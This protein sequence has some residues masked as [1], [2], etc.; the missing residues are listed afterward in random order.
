MGT[1]SGK[2]VIDGS[3]ANTGFATA[4]KAANAFFNV[5]QD[6]VKQLDTLATRLIQ[7]G[8]ASKVGF[9]AAITQAADFEQR[10]SAI[11]AV[12]GATKDQ[13]KLVSAEA[14]KIGA[15]TV[16]SAGQAADAIEELVKAGISL[17]NVLDGAGRA[18]VNLAA[19]GQIS[20]PEAA[21][22][23]A[24]AMNNFRLT[25]EDMPHIADLISG[26]ANA[27][28]ISVSEFGISLQ[29]AGAVAAL[30]GLKLDDLAVAIA[31]MGNAG[32]KGSDAGTSLKTMLMN[33]QPTT[34]RQ[35]ALFAEMNLVTYDSAKA[36]QFLTSKGF[37][38]LNAS[39]GE[40]T[41]AAQNY[42]EA[43][44]K[45]NAGTAE[46]AQYTDQM[47]TKQGLLQNQF[48]TSAG[49]IKSLAE[50]QEVLK[51]S[52]A[53]MTEQQKLLNL[54][55]L[56]GADAVRAAAILAKNGAEGYNKLQ[57]AMANVTAMDVANTK[58]DNLKGSIE[59]LKG[60]VQTAAIVIGTYFIPPIRKIIDLAT[61]ALNAFLR[62]PEGV[63]K[64]IVMLIAVSGTMSILTG[65]FI[66]FLFILPGLLIKLAA[67][68]FIKPLFGGI[69]STIKGIVPL[70][71]Q[72]GLK[73][74]QVIGV[75]GGMLS[76]VTGFGGII[77][78][79][80][81]RLVLFSGIITKLV[82][83]F[84]ILGKVIG[85]AFGPWGAIITTVI[86]V[87]ML[88][89]NHWQPFH[90]LVNKTATSIKN[91]AIY[92]GGVLV[93]AFQ[94]AREW[95]VNVFAPAAWQG[96]KDFWAVIMGFVDYLKASWGPS[97]SDAGNNIKNA[98]TDGL[99]KANDAIQNG[100][101]PAF[102]RLVAAVKP[103]I[104]KIVEVV[105]TKLVPALVDIWNKI[106]PSLEKLWTAFQ[107]I[108]KVLLEVVGVVVGV[109]LVAL[110]EFVKFLIGTVI[111]VLIS[112]Y[113]DY[114]VGFI[115]VLSWLADIILGTVLPAI[116]DFVTWLVS[117][118][119]SAFSETADT[120]TSVWDN[121]AA[122]FT[123][124]WNTITD[125]F[126]KASDFIKNVI[127]GIGDFISSIW[128][129]FWSSD[130]GGLVLNAIGLVTDAIT[131]F[132]KFSHY[133]WSA[134]I[135]FIQLA[136]NLAAATISAI[137]TGIV[138]WVT[139]AWNNL[140]N[141]LTNIW[142]NITVALTIAWNYMYVIISVAVSQ[143]ITWLVNTWNG[144]VDFLNTIWNLVVAA[145][146]AAW[147]ALYS[148][149]SPAVR[150]VVD[151]IVGLI[152]GLQ[153][154]LRD[155]WNAIVDF[156]KSIWNNL[157]QPVKDAITDVIDT[158]KTL[159]EKLKD[160]LSDAGTWLL[161]IGGD[162]MDGL[163][164]GLNGGIDTVRNFLNGLT[165]MIPENKGPEDKDKHLLEANGEWIMQSLINGFANRVPD[166]KKALNGIT[167]SIP[168]YTSINQAAVG[169][170]ISSKAAS[171][172]S[173]NNSQSSSTMVNVNV[174]P[175]AGMNEEQLAT[176]TA[177]QIGYK[178]STGGSSIPAVVQEMK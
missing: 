53:G 145:A 123:G 118:L 124:L 42:S 171:T 51:T 41:K 55:M 130:F 114:V 18:T 81:G 115:N 54:E 45:G 32:I 3:G 93:D 142:A 19:A 37:K 178:L 36:V 139:N 20:L 125:A 160:A 164:R 11:Q 104:D 69:F 13:M 74:V 47:L 97:I 90:D 68:A 117:G 87:L 28:A 52:T 26:A 162:I 48:F 137:V 24:A 46:N 21:S 86:S 50:I 172:S 96:L 30:S 116:I 103:A 62:L 67:F 132:E 119:S 59:Q 80:G 140:V 167:T 78:T 113:A 91:F 138:T 165:A 99:S 25:G 40:I 23:A 94:K 92:L 147:N 176:S 9:V 173:I 110:Y 163:I 111:P 66:K 5:L 79:V 107:P 83:G 101:I 63:R 168:L 144:L 10:L 85:F 89:Y 146:T 141:T 143:I 95:V 39:Y 121:V 16:F 73:A 98:F 17:Q 128:N 175:S 33:L 153:D 133:I 38:P 84:G 49:K 22:I 31:E 4:Q 158:V 72:L 27:S 35:R 159:P 112:L 131:L 14:L 88:L 170:A 102:Q 60:S 108:L 134:I 43:L 2:I 174:Y 157:A 109:V 77:S 127:Q 100:L 61:A 148:A 82:A 58:L 129:G 166:L 29:Q 156:A 149:V 154:R 152:Q 64:F 70:L 105:Q 161:K 122:F 151:F 65:L 76:K 56:F 135:Y 150:V 126:Q 120:A 155:I 6:R 15:D 1:A 57:A 7:V 44:G 71:G 8:A 75:V 169:S 12:A 34:D 177:R 106:G 136:W